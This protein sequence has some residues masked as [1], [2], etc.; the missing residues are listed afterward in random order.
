MKE[1]VQGRKKEDE[2]ERGNGLKLPRRRRKKEGEKA[3]AKLPSSLMIALCVSTEKKGL[4]VFV[5]E[6]FLL[7]FPKQPLIFLLCNRIL[8]YA[9]MFLE[10][11][12]PAE[13]QVAV[14][15]QGANERSPGKFKKGSNTGKGSLEDPITPE[16]NKGFQR[17]TISLPG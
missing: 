4:C 2:E 10:L 8:T 11:G 15:P 16:V 5:T 17:I 9:I 6:G 13:S 1:M 3:G 12:S 14:K 7:G